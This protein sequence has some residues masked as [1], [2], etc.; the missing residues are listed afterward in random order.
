MHAV[1]RTPGSFGRSGNALLRPVR[2]LL[3]LG[4]VDLID[5]LHCLLLVCLFCC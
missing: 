3:K 5:L 2:R 1:Q 4:L